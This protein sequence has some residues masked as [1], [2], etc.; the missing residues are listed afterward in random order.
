MVN[1]VHQYQ[2]WWVFIDNDPWVI[3][4]MTQAVT[5]STDAMERLMR[6]TQKWQTKKNHQVWTEK[7]T[8]ISTWIPT[9][10]VNLSSQQIAL[11]HNITCKVEKQ[12][13]FS[14]KI[15]PQQCLAFSFVLPCSDCRWWQMNLWRWNVQFLVSLW[16]S[17]PPWLFSSHIYCIPKLV[18]V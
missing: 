1:M 10:C 9:K 14:R 6:H 13:S 3:A 17:F 15:K 16:L 4:T 5:A 18:F 12:A 8:Y 7:I 11:M 2:T